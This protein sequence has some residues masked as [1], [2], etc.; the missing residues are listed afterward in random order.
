MLIAAES[1]E[2][3]LKIANSK[4]ANLVIQ[5]EVDLGFPTVK[6]ELVLWATLHLN[7]FLFCIQLRGGGARERRVK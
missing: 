5:E 6:L 7:W 3:G 1:W 4:G 2:L